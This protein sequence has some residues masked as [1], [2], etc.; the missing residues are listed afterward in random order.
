MLWQ[1]AHFLGS[2]LHKRYVHGKCRRFDISTVVLASNF[3]YDLLI[4]QGDRM[5]D[6]IV[7]L[8]LERPEHETRLSKAIDAFAR[9]RE[10]S[11]GTSAEEYD[12]PHIMVRTEWDTSG[13]LS[14]KL[15]F[16]DRS[17]ADAFMRFWQAE[18]GKLS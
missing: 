4:T 14:K 5:S 10:Q 17:V 12:A 8:G 13:Q 18:I 9:W 11:I 7:T 2:I 3:V 15:T 1:V 16:Q 6:V